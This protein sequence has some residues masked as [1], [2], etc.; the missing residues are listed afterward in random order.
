ML[1]AGD[2]AIRYGGDEFAVL[3]LGTHAAGA[4]HLSQRII[5]LFAQRTDL[6]TSSPRVTLSPGVASMRMLG[7]DCGATLLKKADEAL[8]EAKGEGRNEVVVASR[9][10][11]R[12]KPVRPTP[13]A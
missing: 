13:V 9:R 12:T 8:Y 6:L 10:S 5:K 11:H 4:V 7:L 3:L 2:I 1:R